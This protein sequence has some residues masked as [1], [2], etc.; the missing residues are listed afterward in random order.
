MKNESILMILY[1]VHIQHQN[2]K[3]K[4]YDYDVTDNLQ[5][6]VLHNIDDN[7][8][9]DYELDIPA[10]ISPF[11][12][13]HETPTARE[14]RLQAVEMLRR[15]STIHMKYDTCRVFPP[16]YV[17]STSLS[18]LDRVND[19]LYN[20]NHNNNITD[21]ANTTTNNNNLYES[22]NEN[23]CKMKM[24]HTTDDPIRR[25]YSAPKYQVRMQANLQ[26]DSTAITAQ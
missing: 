3:L 15:R 4:D 23:I 1:V 24:N 7:N 20:H 6:N 21:N 18:F 25:P 16:G 14:R 22:D 11:L 13:H 26:K 10:N 12:L 9:D 5:Y 8:I 2:I 19:N 17:N